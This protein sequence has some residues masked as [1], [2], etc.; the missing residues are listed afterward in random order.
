LLR[1][2]AGVRPRAR[3]LALTAAALAVTASVAAV[4]GTSAAQD[5]ASV[6]TKAAAAA[7]W[8]SV[9]QVTALSRRPDWVDI[10]YVGDQG[11]IHFGT[12]DPSDGD[13]FTG[14]LNRGVAARDTKVTGVSRYPGRLDL[15]V[16]GSDQ[17]TTRSTRR[18][19]TRTS[20]AGAPCCGTAG[21]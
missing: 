17:A 6:T 2:R 21:S 5:A 7:E 10:V 1:T 16:V 3:K 4:A 9:T 11:R 13:W 15:F 20:T 12:R 18:T 8:D 14:F 19:W